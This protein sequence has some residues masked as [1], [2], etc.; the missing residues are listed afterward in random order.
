[1]LN[2]PF[3]VAARWAILLAF[4]IVCLL[5]WSGSP[6]R[7][8]AATSPTVPLDSSS[9]W[10][11][12]RHDS[13]NTGSSPIVARY[14]GDRP[15]SFKTARGIF[16]TPVI[17]GDG[18]IYVGSADTYF[19]AISTS[20]RLRWR[21]KTGGLIDAAGALS[22][23]DPSLRSSALTFGS[24]DEQLYHVTTPRAGRPRVVWKFRA[25]VPPVPPQ[26]VDW[27]EGNVAVGPGGECCTP[28]TP[29]VRV[30]RS[31]RWQPALDVHRRATRCGPLRRSRLMARASG[32]RVDLHIYHLSATGQALW[33]TFVPGYVVSSPAIGSDGT[34]YVGAFDSKLYALDPSH[35]RGALELQDERS[36]L[37]LA[38]ARRG[39][40]WPTDA[41]YIASA[42]G[43]VYALTP[44]GRLL[45]SYDTGAPVRSSPTLGR[46]PRRR[47]QRHRLRRLLQRQAVRDQ[48]EH[49]PPALV[50]QHH[51]QQSCS[52]RPQQPQCVAGARQDRG[53]HRRPGRLRLLRAVRLLPAPARP[54]LLDW[55][56]PRAH[57]ATSAACSPSMS[58]ATSSRARLSA[59]FLRQRHSTYAWSS[60]G[61]ERP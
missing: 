30:R 43:S 22:A 19:Y 45:W 55:G 42:N 25:S 47:S 14:R 8:A 5:A 9:P 46:C 18:T 35:R 15:W 13:R 26:K 4:A 24:A 11:E 34:V 41:I 27:W 40:E 33:R 36:H 57:D 21:L 17:G 23:F 3:P 32:A 60:V 20:G 31:S 7:A 59:G 51:P 29:A 48:R 58:A 10:P 49:R 16:S 50:V 38:G 54:S 44:Q 61:K 52:P 6:S 53:V 12:M 37:R 56:D 28:A 1:M 2:K 39:R